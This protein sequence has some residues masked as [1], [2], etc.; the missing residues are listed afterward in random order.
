M[1]ERQC[2]SCKHFIDSNYYCMAFPNGI[3]NKL[4]KGEQKHNSI[5]KGQQGNT[6]YEKEQPR[7]ST[8]S[9]KIT[10][11]V[12]ERIRV[13]K[14]EKKALKRIFKYGSEC[15]KDF[16]PYEIARCVRSFQKDLPK[17]PL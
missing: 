6:I 4:L 9:G 16:P 12:W 14:A 1:E 7:A 5:I 2:A 15:I 8:H 13:S 3:P 17:V 11:S 10:I